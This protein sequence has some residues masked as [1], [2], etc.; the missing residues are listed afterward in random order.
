MRALLYLGLSAVTLVAL[1]PILVVIGVLHLLLIAVP[2]GTTLKAPISRRSKLSW[3]LFL[4][5][6]P[7]IG[8]TI[9]HFRFRSSLFLGRPYQPS[10]H[11]LGARNWKDSNDDHG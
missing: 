1:Y 4:L 9:F 3:C 6:L 10:A 5:F 7:F 8:A 11:D 2:I